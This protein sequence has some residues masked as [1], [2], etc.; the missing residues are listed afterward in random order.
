[1]NLDNMMSQLSMEE[2]QNSNPPNMDMNMNMNMNM[3]MNMDMDMNMNMDTTFTFMDDELTR[4]LFINNLDIYKPKERYLEL[5]IPNIYCNK[6]F[7]DEDFI[8][9][10]LKIQ[11]LTD[12]SN[13]TKD[14]TIDYN[15]INYI[16]ANNVVIDFTDKT[17]DTCK[18]YVKVLYLYQ[19]VNSYYSSLSGMRPLERIKYIPGDLLIWIENIV[20]IIRYILDNDLFNFKAQDEHNDIDMKIEREY[21]NELIYGLNLVVCHLKML[22]NHYRILGIPLYNIEEQHIKKM[23]QVLNNMCV[24][25]IYLYSVLDISSNK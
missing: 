25:I 18:I 17:L 22:L 9:A 20:G 13:D 14:N 24:I 7:D 3:D 16:S 8:Y 5:G 23:F 4:D 19:Y 1:M 21:F 12:N 11:E 6:Y 2:K 10:K 15:V